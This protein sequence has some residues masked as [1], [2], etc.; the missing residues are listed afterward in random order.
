MLTCTWIINR[1]Q[2]VGSRDD[3]STGAGATRGFLVNNFKRR[4]YIPGRRERLET[5]VRVADV[6]GGIVIHRGVRRMLLSDS[7][8]MLGV[9]GDRETGVESSDQGYF[10]CSLSRAA[11]SCQQSR[12]LGVPSPN[13]NGM[14]KLSQEVRSPCSP[15]ACS[16][17]IASRAEPFEPALGLLHN[18]NSALCY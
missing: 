6:N 3:T 5:S 13:S 14:N 18:P 8:A 7:T 1:L 11:I 16:G 10:L 12:R 17:F 9:A 2:G 15:K 4:R